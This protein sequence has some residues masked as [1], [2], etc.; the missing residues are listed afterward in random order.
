M[1][2]NCRKELP[3]QKKSKNGQRNYNNV[4]NDR[5]NQQSPSKYELTNKAQ[6]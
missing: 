1:I 4:V 2:L 5:F 3:T 6:T